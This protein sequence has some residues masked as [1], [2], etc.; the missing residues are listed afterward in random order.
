MWTMWIIVHIEMHGPITRPWK[1]GRLNYQEAWTKCQHFLKIVPLKLW[2]QRHQA[3][4]NNILVEFYGNISK[5]QNEAY[6]IR[7]FLVT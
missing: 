1:G 7:P 3:R 5:L 2:A 6:L 4:M